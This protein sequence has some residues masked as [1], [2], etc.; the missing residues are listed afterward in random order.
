MAL[1]IALIPPVRIGQSLTIIRVPIHK[2]VAYILLSA[3][4]IGCPAMTKQLHPVSPR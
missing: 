2:P 4:D 1:V 3:I